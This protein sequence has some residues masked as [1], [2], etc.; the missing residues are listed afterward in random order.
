VVALHHGRYAFADRQ[1][2]DREVGLRF[3]KGAAQDQQAVVLCATQTVEIS[4]DCDADFMITDLAPMDVLLQRLGRLHRHGGRAGF[5]PA[6]F[7]DPQ[8]VVLVPPQD[9]LAPL[10]SRGGAQG[11]G[12]GERSAYPDVLCLQATLRALRDEARFPVLDIPRHNRELVESSCGRTALQ[13][14]AEALGGPWPGHSRLL[15]GKQ[16]AQRSAAGFV[17]IDWLEPWRAAVAGELTLEAKTR[18]GLDGID[19]EL[20]VR[21]TSP[22]GNPIDR[23]TVPAWMLPPLP[24]GDVAPVPPVEDLRASSG[25]FGFSVRGQ[26]FRYDRHG[27]AQDGVPRK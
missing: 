17:C 15:Y 6:P 18:L 20:P 13:A 16:Y 23:L 2:L 7:A 19:M 24:A 14:L 5:R 11:L 1:L 4:V 27:L 26:P 9:D 10:L 3:G 12:L 21:Q 25:G 8:C 22:F